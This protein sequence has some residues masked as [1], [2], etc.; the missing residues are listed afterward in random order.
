MEVSVLVTTYNHE[1][2]IA[3]ALDSVLMQQTNF[4]YEIVIAED[5]STD[6]T[7]SIVLDFQR[8]NPRKIRLVLP[9]KN[10]GCGGNRVFAQAFELAQGEH[11]ALL[12]GDDYWISPRKLQMQ[13]E[14]LEAHPDC[15]LCFHNAM[16][17]YEDGNRA[18][19]LY[20]PADQKRISVLEDILQSN[21]IAGCTP[22]IRKEVLGGFPE[23]YYEL[24]WGDWSLYILC[25]QYGKI[26]Y[27]DEIL[28]IYRIHREGLWSRYNAIQKLEALIAFYETMNANLAFRFNDIVEPLV[29]ARRK[30]LAA[31]RALVK[32]AEKV[33]PNGA[34]VLVMARAGEDLP[35]LRGHQTWAF[36]DRS[37]KQTQR[38]FASGAAGSAEAP[39]IGSSS[40]YEFRLYRGTTQAKL[41]ASVT[42]RQ[43]GTG[44]D[45]PCLERKPYENGAF[46]KASP[47]PVPSGTKPEKTTISWSTGDGSPGVIQVLMKSLQMQYPANDDEAIEQFEMLRAKGGEYLLV[48]RQVLPW[49]EEYAG[50]KNHLDGHYKLI[51]SDETCL[52]YDLRQMAAEDHSGGGELKADVKIADED[53]GGF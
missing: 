30:E 37:G 29:S 6:R 50:L 19:L 44:L 4:D 21:F 2:Y 46:I 35:P 33:L 42:V 5:C 15:T 36:P 7:R 53:N 40:T 39:W 45:L 31:V 51:Q 20:N 27:I 38:Q 24:L 17:I 3:Q 43:I 12:D 22:M 11:V 47:N 49:L 14:F 13:V 26:G 32:T 9:A 52:I 48:S 8:Q 23:W 16:R 10:L 18:S 34:I 41:L 28:G 1:K 25:A